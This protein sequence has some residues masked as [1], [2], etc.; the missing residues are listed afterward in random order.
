M[1][2]RDLLKLQVSFAKEPLKETIFCKRDLLWMV[3]C[4]CTHIRPLLS[5][6]TDVWGGY[7]Q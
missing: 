6:Y 7:D 2:G 4:A 5:Y 3:E 1:D